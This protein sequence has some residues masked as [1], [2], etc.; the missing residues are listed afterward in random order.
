MLLILEPNRSIVKGR[1]M[2][3]ATLALLIPIFAIVGGYAVAIMKIRERGNS[4]NN[5]LQA[6]NQLLHIELDKLRERV[7]VLEQLVT[8]ESFQLKREFKRV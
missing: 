6:D 8:D 1:I 3:P 5:K 4:A 2:N 7:E